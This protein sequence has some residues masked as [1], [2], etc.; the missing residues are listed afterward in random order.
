ML[1][2]RVLLFY[3]AS[4]MGSVPM[5]MDRRQVIRRTEGPPDLSA[6]ESVRQGLAESNTVGWQLAPTSIDLATRVYRHQEAQRFLRQF[7]H[8]VTGIMLD[9]VSRSSPD[10][11]R[12]YYGVCVE[13]GSFHSQKSYRVCG[14]FDIVSARVS[15]AGWWSGVCCLL[16]LL[17]WWGVFG[18]AFG[19][20]MAC[21]CSRF[22]SGS[23]SFPAMF[24]FLVFVFS[25]FLV[26]RGFL[27][28][29]CLQC[30]LSV[31]PA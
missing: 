4:R 23:C 17:F 22:F 15:L 18:V 1:L 9:Q 14:G 2:P 10:R 29:V 11:V 19:L 13:Q 16:L 6:F 7:L 25:L 8:Q 26:F 3:L 27:S 21:S 31:A 20:R 24:L 5:E 30:R 28:L 12:V